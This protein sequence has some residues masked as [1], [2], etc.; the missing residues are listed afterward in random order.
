MFISVVQVDWH[1]GPE[2]RLRLYVVRP[3]L[4][5][6]HFAKTKSLK[7]FDGIEHWKDKHPVAHTP[8]CSGLA[9]GQR[10]QCNS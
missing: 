6:G 1:S 10:Y 4:E 9:S 8:A 5:P 7:D 2:Q 3:R